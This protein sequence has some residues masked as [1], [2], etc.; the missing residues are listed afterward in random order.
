MKKLV[1][2]S[3]FIIPFFFQSKAQFTLTNTSTISLCELR[4]GTWPLDLQRIIKKNDT[5]YQLQFRDQQ[6]TTEVNM[7]VLRFGNLTQLKYFQKCLAALKQGSN[8]DQADFKEYAVKRTDVKKE[9]C[10]TLTLTEGSVI[11]FKQAE[12]DKLAAAI[13]TL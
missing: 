1:L 7:S 10:Y 13:K 6:Y 4:N 12:A 2:L 11:N 8:G 3:L 5:L 9:V